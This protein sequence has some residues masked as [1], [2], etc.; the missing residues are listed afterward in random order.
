MPLVALE[1]LAAGKPV[2]LTPECPATDYIIPGMNGAVT[3]HDPTEMA[4][5]ILRVL[6][7]GADRALSKRI[8][9]S[10]EQLAWSKVADRYLAAAADVARAKVLPNLNSY[11]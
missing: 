11:E 1:A 9:S 8:R 3:S 6:P 7:L 5:H 2:V 10:V 4:D